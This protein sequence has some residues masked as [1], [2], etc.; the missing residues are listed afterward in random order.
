MQVKLLRA[1]FREIS[2]RHIST[3]VEEFSSFWVQLL[4]DY[5]NDFVV[6]AINSPAKFEY[7]EYDQAFAFVSPIL[8]W[9]L[10]F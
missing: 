8:C 5:K 2:F 3:I 1:L 7:N 6:G 9:N 4:K 10:L